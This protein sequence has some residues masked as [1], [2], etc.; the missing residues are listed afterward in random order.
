MNSNS[1]D[2]ETEDT[3]LLGTIL[4]VPLIIEDEDTSQTIKATNLWIHIS[5]ADHEPS[6]NPN[7]INISLT[8]IYSDGYFH[9]TLTSD[10]TRRLFR[11]NV[12]NLN[13]ESDVNLFK[14]LGNLF[15]LD[16]ESLIESKEAEGYH[17]KLKI[18]AKLV[19][20]KSDYDDKNELLEDSDPNTNPITISIK[21]DAKLAITVG[22]FQLPLIEFEDHPHLAEEGDLFN[23]I[24]LYHL[25]NEQ[26]VHQLTSQTRDLDALKLETD[27]LVLSNK[28]IKLDYQKIIKDLEEKFY[29]ALNTKKDKI[30]ELLYGDD[31]SKDKKL[32][33]LNAT[34]L[35]REGKFNEIDKDAISDDISDSSFLSGNKRKR[36]KG[37]LLSRK[38]KKTKNV[39]VEEST[40]ED[41]SKLKVEA[42]TTEGSNSNR[43]SYDDNEKSDDQNR[44][45]LKQEPGVAESPVLKSDLYNDKESGLSKFSLG[46]FIEDSLAKS[47]KSQ[48]LVTP[49]D[50]AK[51]D[52]EYSDSDLEGVEAG[53][54][55]REE[56]T[57]YSDD[58]D[59]DEEEPKVDSPG[60]YDKPEPT[61]SV[62]L[63]DS[64]EESNEI[65]DSLA[66]TFQIDSGVP[67]GVLKNDADETDY[68]DSE[69]ES[70]NKVEP[71]KEDQVDKGLETDYSDDSE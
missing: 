47:N 24:D 32:V 33:G 58:T 63:K 36:S 70:G 35:E 60:N 56:E 38:K 44:V 71:I 27:L 13:V 66:D 28:S 4:K 11:K 64:S 50:S 34:F 25:Q 1:L 53:E 68:S 55:T 30:Y 31:Q 15:P 43:K 26:L 40:S 67:A 16:L 51:E 2:D 57:D 8:A 9:K 22:T 21:T 49:E 42:G 46:S 3:V 17:K 41:D 7:F 45:H 37:S 19:A 14:L 6:N 23:W 39:V 29:Q 20:H 12:P 48:K 59:A 18:T 10:N 5:R 52:T 54:G 62:E 65:K 69:D 61:R